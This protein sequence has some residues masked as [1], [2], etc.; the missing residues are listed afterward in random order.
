MAYFTNSDPKDRMQLIVS[1]GGAH[2]MT[3]LVFSAGLADAQTFRQ[4]AQVCLNH[5]RAIQAG[6]EFHT[7]MPLFAI[8]GTDEMDVGQYAY[9]LQKD[10]VGHGH[11]VVNTLPATGGYELMTTEYNDEGFDIETDY[12]PGCT[13]LTNDVSTPGWIEP[14]PID[15]SN[16]TVLGCVSVGVI[17]E[18]VGIN[19][20]RIR[21]GQKKLLR[22]WTLWWCAVNTTGV[23]A[24]G[25]RPQ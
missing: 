11:G 13:L 4:G 22:F 24:S 25:D 15:H 14:A 6:L 8:N 10:I 5:D 16:H 21:M 17:T 9:N 3:D 23:S 1:G 7:S 19:R 20:A 18:R 2:S 12:V